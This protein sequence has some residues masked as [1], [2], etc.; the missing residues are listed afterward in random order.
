MPTVTVT[1]GISPEA[2]R[3]IESLCAF[4]AWRVPLA[5]PSDMVN[6]AALSELRANIDALALGGRIDITFT[7]FKPC[8]VL[9]IAHTFEVHCELDSDAVLIKLALT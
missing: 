8:D 3:T 7:G 2:A 5:W 4:N 1:S 6:S 9:Y